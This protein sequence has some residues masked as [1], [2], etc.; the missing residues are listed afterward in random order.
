MVSVFSSAEG[1]LLKGANK[2]S[3]Y[4]VPN[5][6]GGKNYVNL[7]EF[8]IGCSNV[9]LCL[10]ARLISVYDVKK[11]CREGASILIIQRFFI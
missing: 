10:N 3:F 4:F 9:W 5:V 6:L 8:K 7:H 11:L 1:R 2:L